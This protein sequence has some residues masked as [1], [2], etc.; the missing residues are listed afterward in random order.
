[1]FMVR[2][3]IKKLKV[4]QLEFQIVIFSG[5]LRG[6]QN[7]FQF[8]RQELIKDYNKV[9][10]PTKKQELKQESDPENKKKRKK[11]R[12]RPRKRPRKKK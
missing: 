2:N 1:M 7:M 11:T 5:E 6:M 12:S 3:H 4:E 8:Q 10:K 9:R